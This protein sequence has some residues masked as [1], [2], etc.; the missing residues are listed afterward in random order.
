MLALRDPLSRIKRV[1]EQELAF[2]DGVALIP[3]E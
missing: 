2:R 1:T 3:E